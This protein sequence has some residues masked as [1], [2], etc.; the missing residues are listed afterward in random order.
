MK[1]QHFLTSYTKIKWVQDLNIK[2]ETMQ[3]LDENIAK[4]FF[5]IYHTNIFSVSYSK[6]NKSKNEQLRLN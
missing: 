1:F 3:D 6:G 4:T 2:P 5:D